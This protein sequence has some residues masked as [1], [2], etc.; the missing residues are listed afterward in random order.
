MS[1]LKVFQR[2]LGKLP[3]KLNNKKLILVIAGFALIGI[4]TVFITRA[5]V[6]GVAIEPESGSRTSAIQP[7]NNDSTASNNASITFKQA[8]G[9]GG[10]GN[11]PVTTGQR[12][13]VLLHGAGADFGAIAQ[14]EAQLNSAVELT[15]MGVKTLMPISNNWTDFLG[16][17]WGYDG[18]HNFQYDPDSPTDEAA[19]QGFVSIVR[20][21]IT[22]AN[23][24]PTYIEGGSN[25]GG[26]LAKMFCDGE[27]FGGRVWGVYM[28]DPVMDTGVLNCNP[29]SNIKKA[30]VGYSDELEEQKPPAASDNY[31]CRSTPWQWYCNDDTTMLV[32]Q[33]T[34]QINN[35][36]KVDVEVYKIAQNHI[37]NYYPIA[38]QLHIGYGTIYGDWWKYYY[39]Q[40]YP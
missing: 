16:N 28:K 34:Q 9:G 6:I 19:Y 13:S 7:N 17:H 12:C 18:P 14:Q 37:Y 8:S 2:K 25:G 5:A 15:S 20:N 11:P 10:G 30:V 35:H 29:S 36:N 40:F 24:G 26:F 33:Y 4:S 38:D 3:T 22:Q 39:N 32:G 31:R 27:D 21:R 1:A 23:C